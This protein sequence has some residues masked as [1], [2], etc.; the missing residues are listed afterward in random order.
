[1]EELFKI[2]NLHLS[3]YP[4]MMPQDI[5][6]LLYQNEF[7]P[8]HMIS[9]SNDSL[10]YLRKEVEELD[11]D[12]EE[13]FVDIGNDLCRLNLSKAIQKYSLEEI[14]EMFIRSGQATVG[15]LTNYLQKI[16]FFRNNFDRF[17]LSFSEDDFNA[18]M[19]YYRGNAYPSVHHSEE[20]KELYK[21]HYRVVRKSSLIED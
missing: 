18:Y 11:S 15:S 19:S 12:E 4:K 16:K 20:Y 2:I 10:E 1:M 21:P 13:L 17:E 7:G 14:N 6:K 9:N 3:M 5:I 8:E